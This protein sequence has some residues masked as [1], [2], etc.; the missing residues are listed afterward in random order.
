MFQWDAVDTSPDLGGQN[1]LK[2]FEMAI[3]HYRRTT[4]TELERVFCCSIFFT[5]IEVY[6]YGPLQGGGDR[7]HRRPPNGSAI[8]LRGSGSPHKTRFHRPLQVHTP[9][10]TSI[11]LAVLA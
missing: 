5:Y 6:F 9:K 8:A 4:W 3:R 11:D 2:T 1:V 7:P 10:G